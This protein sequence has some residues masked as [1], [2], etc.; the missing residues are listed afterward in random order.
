[1]SI[2]ESV[3][4][5]YK[6]MQD[7]IRTCVNSLTDNERN[8]AEISLICDN[9]SSYFRSHWLLMQLKKHYKKQKNISFKRCNEHGLMDVVIGGHTLVINLL[10]VCGED[11]MTNITTLM[12]H[13]SAQ[14]TI[15]NAKINNDNNDTVLNTMDN[16]MCK[17]KQSANSIFYK[18]KCSNNFMNTE[19]TLSFSCICVF[20]EYITGY[21]PQLCTVPTVSRITFGPLI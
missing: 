20:G 9:G 2:P 21:E 17:S 13:S 18:N 8:S 12:S 15:L 10:F 6:D 19:Y 16:V 5:L 4:V 7:V 14:S 1:M 11:V 3:T